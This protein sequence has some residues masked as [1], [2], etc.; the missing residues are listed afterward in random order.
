MFVN[1]SSKYW[2]SGLVEILYGGSVYLEFTHRL[3]SRKTNGFCRIVDVTAGL[4]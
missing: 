3:L 1:Q 4:S 2:W